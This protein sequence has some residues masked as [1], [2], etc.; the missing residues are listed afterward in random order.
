MNYEL[1]HF[2]TLLLR[3]HATEDSNTPEITIL[4]CDEN[5]RNLG[6]IEK[7]IQK[8]AQELLD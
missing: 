7:Q 5:K 6:L 4:W 2:N 1:R 8:R 3:F